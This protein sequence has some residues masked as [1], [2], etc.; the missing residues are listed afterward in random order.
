MLS[1][2]IV[3]GRE[4]TLRLSVIDDGPLDARPMFPP[5]R[6]SVE[7]WEQ[8]ESG[9]RLQVI[10]RLRFAVAAETRADQQVDHHL[11]ELVCVSQHLGQPGR[12]L[13]HHLYSAAAEMVAGELQRLLHQLVDLHRQARC[14]LVAGH[15]QEGLD[16]AGAALS[17]GTNAQGP[18]ALAVAGRQRLQQRRLAEHDRQR[19]VELV[20]DA[21]QQHAEGGQLLAL[22]Q[23]LALGQ[24]KAAL[25]GRQQ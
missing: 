17:G 8:D 21:G 11:I 9:R 18:V 1:T 24:P 12:Q 2:P 5:A 15:R 6:R 13:L 22:V 20:R 10:L 25:H 7:N 23:R 14:R 16:D 19:I 3:M 4:T